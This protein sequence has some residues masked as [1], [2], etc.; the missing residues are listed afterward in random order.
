V[1]YEISERHA[2]RLVGLARSTNRYRAK[3]TGRDAALRSR[4][5]ELADE[6]FHLGRGCSL[7]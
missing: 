7:S 1:E 5:K 3:K 6:T 2:C 4:L